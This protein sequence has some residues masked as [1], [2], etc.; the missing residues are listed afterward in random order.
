MSSA[1][2][3]CQ[4]GNVVV[5]VELLSCVRLFAT[6]WTVACQTPLSMGFP[7]QEYW[8]GLPFPSPGDLPNPHLL[9][10][11]VD[12]LPLSHQGNKQVEMVKWLGGDFAQ[13]G[14][15]TS[16]GRWNLKEE[17]KWDTWRSAQRIFQAQGTVGL[18][19]EDNM[20]SLEYNEQGG[21][22]QVGHLHFIL[23]AARSFWKVLTGVCC[24]LIHNFFF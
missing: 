9:H 2:D 6:P 17:E 18:E 4:H 10:W 7:R 11:Q 3:A 16:L 19:F 22:S 1:S 20:V 24:G 14:Q 12:S 15:G 8:S 21:G 13:G 5:V 23:R